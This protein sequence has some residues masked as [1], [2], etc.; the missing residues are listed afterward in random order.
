MDNQ[1][2]I[3]LSKDNKF[4]AHIKHID[5]HYHYIQEVIEAGKVQM[6]YVLTSEN[7]ADIITK[8]LTW[9]LLE[10]F[11]DMLGLWFT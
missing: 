11:R 1:G 2:A 5:I 6:V 7:V 8:A 4:H 9:P 10:K 3:A